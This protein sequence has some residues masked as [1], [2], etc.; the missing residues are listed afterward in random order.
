MQWTRQPLPTAFLG[1]PVCLGRS[2]AEITERRHTTQLS[3]VDMTMADRISLVAAIV[4][5][6]L[7]V[8][9]WTRWPG[10]GALP[11]QWGLDDKPTWFAPRWLAFSLLPATGLLALAVTAR[12]VTRR[13][14]PAGI[15]FSSRV[16]VAIDVLHLCLARGYA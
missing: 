3:M 1:D 13:M 2:G 6:G 4:L 12:R 15:S 9:G 11:M 10:E 16:V 8:L 14:M 7:A 5:V